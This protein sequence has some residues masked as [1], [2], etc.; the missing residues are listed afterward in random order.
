MPP[1]TADSP[2]RKIAILGAGPAGL[3]AA[4]ALTDTP[5][6]R[7][8][9]E[10]TIYQMGWRAGGKFGTGRVPPHNWVNLNGT[11][12]LFGGYANGLATVRHVFEELN[13]LG[14]MSYGTFEDN[15]IPI[16]FL[17]FKHEWKG[18]IV[19]WRILMPS[20][21]VAPGSP[22]VWLPIIDYLQMAVKGVFSEIFGW[23]ALNAIQWP[24]AS[25]PKGKRGPIGRLLGRLRTWLQPVV[26]FIGTAILWGLVALGDA[27]FGRRG[28]LRSTAWWMKFWRG[29]WRG[30]LTPF[31]GWLLGAYRLWIMVDNVTTT[32]IGLVADEVDVYGLESIDRWDYREWLCRHGGSEE[33]VNCALV[34]SWYSAVASYDRGDRSKPLL[35]AGVSVRALTR[36]NLA[37]KG[38]FAYSPH[39]E[40]GESVVGP[41]YRLLRHRGVQFKFFHRIWNLEPSADGTTIARV[42]V[43]RQVE[44]VGGDPAG[45]EPLI[46]LE[47]EGKPPLMAWPD[48]PKWELIATQEARGHDLDSFYSDWKGGKRFFLEHGTDYDDL[49]FAMP[50]GVVPFHCRDLLDAHPS[51]RAL[52]EH[53]RGTETQSLRLWLTPDLAGLGFPYPLPI[54]SLQTWPLTTW[55]DNSN[56]LPNERW[57]AEKQPHSIAS[58]Y[59]PLL[60]PQFPPGPDDAEY[61]KRQNEVAA[62]HAK[63]FLETDIANLW[64]KAT[65]PTNP[66]GIDEV[67]V[68][69]RMWRSNAGPIER[70][71]LALPGATRHRFAA[72]ESSY[73]NLIVAGDWTRNGSYIGT[74][75]GAVMSGLMASRRLCG[76]P[77]ALIGE[78]GY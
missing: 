40:V 63:R 68:V 35:A 44:L 43:E 48:S 15:L 3:T 61:P 65:S 23:R 27:L 17:V 28:A 64:P 18:R 77:R 50:V 41:M 19:D 33:L 1:E 13:R 32:I 5:E 67:L 49:V 4:I 71:T 59:G 51:W 37:Y 62:E 14:D 26:Q 29:V 45:Y 56:L 6:L 9:H 73:S 75:D 46:P 12:Y 24:G 42:E 72:D 78:K 16:N 30:V 31:K 58:I 8:K 38:A 52:T 60:C 74:A 11:H 66:N 47:R 7:E 25:P 2:K 34:L 36:A 20:N 70:Y 76:H 53:V 10:V 22:G 54:V 21:R 55:E 69:D 39:E 57:P